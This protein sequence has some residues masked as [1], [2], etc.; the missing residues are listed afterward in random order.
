MRALHAPPSPEQFGSADTHSLLRNMH[1]G[2]E[3]YL[4]GTA[5]VS[6]RSAQEVREVISLVRPHTVLVELC[7]ARAR[8]LHS[9]GGSDADFLRD[10]LGSLFAPGA[11]VGQ[12]LFK[13]SLQG[14]YRFLRSLGMDPGAEFKAAIDAASAHGARVVYGDRDVQD[15]LQRLAGAVRLQDVLRMMSAEGPRPPQHL[16]EFFERGGEASVGAFEAQVE[17]MK[18]RG[19]A[20]EMSDYLRQLNPQ[21][22]AA[23]IDER[24]EHMTRQLAGMRG[25][26]VGVVGLAHLDGIERRWEQ[27][28]YGTGGG[29]GVAAISGVKIR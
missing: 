3:I 5:H 11:N 19:M 17:A 23:L 6:K 21:L 24:D 25:R 14:F 20:R 9:G 4:V 16:V 27:M 13:L 10:A 2:A 22:A 15:T 7:P 28:G 12:Q 26:V 8:R 1:T 18:T 29:G